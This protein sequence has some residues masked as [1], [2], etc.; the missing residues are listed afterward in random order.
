MKD[1]QYA[2]FDLFE[3]AKKYS[4]ND[5]KN[6]FGYGCKVYFSYD[7]S[8]CYKRVGNVIRELGSS[9][10]KD[11]KA[12]GYLY[13][14]EIPPTDKGKPQSKKHF[15]SIFE[16]GDLVEDESGK[17]I[18]ISDGDIS[19]L[20]M[21]V[22]YYNDPAINITKLSIDKWYD[23]VEEAIEQCRP[24]P[25][26]FKVDGD[27]AILS[28]AAI[29]RISF[30][31]SM[32][33]LLGGKRSCSDREQLC[34]ACSLFGNRFAGGR[35]RVTDAICLS[36]KVKVNSVT[37]KELSSPKLSY[38]PF[39]AKD[40]QDPERRPLSF[41]EEG[42][43]IRGRKFYWHN[44]SSDYHSP[45]KTD[46][47]STMELIGEN[48][49]VT[50]GFDIYF[51]R[52]TKKQLEELKWVI[53]L[54]ENSPDGSLCHK[55]GHGKPLGLGSVKM[56]ID[57]M[58]IREF[59]E[60]GGYRLSRKD[61]T[62]SEP[63]DISDNLQIEHKDELLRIMDINAIDPSSNLRITY[64]YVVGASE[65]KRSNEEAAHRWYS[66]NKGKKTIGGRVLPP[67]LDSEGNDAIGNPLTAV[68]PDYS[69]EETRDTHT[70]FSLSKEMDKEYEVV[71]T[72]FLD[73]SS[74]KP[75]YVRFIFDDGYMGSVPYWVFGPDIIDINDISIGDRY[76]VKYEKMAKNGKNEKW[77]IVKKVEG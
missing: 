51:D 8:E 37:L 56:V 62:L 33:E 64:P 41:D 13:I 30:K 45:L 40:M 65:V 68:K 38:M 67:I 4:R 11:R 50:F 43:E 49:P 25:V 14:G 36:E 27:R 9:E 31:R 20:K 3:N 60:E 42:V 18:E 12:E 35:I 22:K 74:G 54:G 6:S 23:G 44:T 24:V 72:A 2:P 1:A 7:K 48:E 63:L 57:S 47:N 19:F 28:L 17:P 69:I 76:I 32:G 5:L 46:R 71:I 61:Y 29:G 52:I 58:E 55:V 70:A 73:D 34:A 59:S 21:L 26:W 53:T 15:E 75:C 16:C 77:E 39:Y 66:Y 10:K